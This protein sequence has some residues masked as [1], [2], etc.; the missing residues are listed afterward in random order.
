MAGVATYNPEL[1]SAIKAR[2]VG[3]KLG[4]LSGSI[5]QI[6]EKSQKWLHSCRWWTRKLGEQLE[7]N[8]FGRVRVWGQVVGEPMTSKL[9]VAELQLVFVQKLLDK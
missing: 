8:R 9:A 1:E 3:L 2:K 6:G 7:G 5:R 4:N